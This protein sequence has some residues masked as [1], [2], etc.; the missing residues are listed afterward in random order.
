MWMVL[1][2]EGPSGRPR[3]EMYRSEDNVSG[4]QPLRMIYLETVRSVKP[5]GENI[6]I[7]THTL[8][9]LPPSLPPSLSQSVRK[10][11]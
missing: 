6:I 3:I 8:S 2:R 5:I 1:Y 10:D 11:F 4:N 7:H 9:S